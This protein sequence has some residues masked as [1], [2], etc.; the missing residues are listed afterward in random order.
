ME[1][2]GMAVAGERLITQ[3]SLSDEALRLRRSVHNRYLAD[4]YWTLIPGWTVEEPTDNPNLQLISTAIDSPC[5]L[6]GAGVSAKE[7]AYPLVEA[8]DL[9]K[10]ISRIFRIRPPNAVR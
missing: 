10:A 1:G 6:F 5:I 8:P 4:V 9:V 7:Q 3:S 2:I